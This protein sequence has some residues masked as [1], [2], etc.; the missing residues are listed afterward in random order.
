MYV[1]MYVWTYSSVRGE[2][3]PVSSA[4]RQGVRQGR[5][6]KL[7][8]CRSAPGY[9]PLPAAAQGDYFLTQHWGEFMEN[10]RLLIFE[11]YCRSQPAND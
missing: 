1:C 9:L 4:A 7:P 6:S 8:S 10:A 5:L 11:T 3:A 2:L